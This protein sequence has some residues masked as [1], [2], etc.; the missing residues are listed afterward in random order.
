MIY[1]LKSFTPEATERE[2]V[3]PPRL[4]WVLIAATLTLDNTHTKFFPSLDRA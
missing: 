2:L 1:A 3:L 4:A